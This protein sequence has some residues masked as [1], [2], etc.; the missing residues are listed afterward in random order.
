MLYNIICGHFCS[1]KISRRSSTLP[2]SFHDTIH[3]SDMLL[4]SPL[5]T[6]TPLQS[7]SKPTFIRQDCLLPVKRSPATQTGLYQTLEAGLVTSSRLTTTTPL[8]KRD[9]SS[10]LIIALFIKQSSLRSLKPASISQLTPTHTSLYGLT[11]SPLYKLFPRSQRGVELLETVMT[12]SMHSD[13][14][15]L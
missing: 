12:P 9:H 3:I 8:W 4:S 5:Q 15:I 11:V 7:P 6:F 14:T 13:P 2:S 10:S 1:L